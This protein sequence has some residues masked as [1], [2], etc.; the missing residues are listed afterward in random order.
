M[1]EK[2]VVCPECANDINLEK[3]TYEV[4]DIISCP[5]CGS[6][7]E[8]SSIKEDGELELLVIEEEK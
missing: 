6:D 1:E 4:G 8:V 5:T 2:K 3:P 7:L